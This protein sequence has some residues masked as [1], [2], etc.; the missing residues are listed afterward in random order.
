M[1]IKIDK[2]TD[3]DFLA[4]LSHIPHPPSTLYIK[5]AL[6]PLHYKIVT[7]VGS[8]SCSEYSKLVVNEICQSLKGQ[9]VSI[10]SG[11]ARGID[12]HVHKAALTH[13]IHTIA[14]VGS[15]LDDSVLYPKQNL[16]LSHMILESGGALISEHS[17]F[18]SS[19][20]WMFPA[21]NRIMVGLSQLVII[22]EA[23]QK[24]GTLITSRLATDYNRDLLVVPNS[25]Y[26]TFSK[27]SN[28][29]IK[30]GAY[31]YTKPSDIFELLKLTIPE[32]MSLFD[33]IPNEIEK[34]ILDS[35]D[36]GFNRTDTILTECSPTFTVSEIIQ[37]ILQLEIG[38]IIK[39]CDGVYIVV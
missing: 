21:R 30:Q 2:I 10:L 25:I 31:V 16:P 34:C 17:Q 39:K 15:G 26:S 24:S 32:S 36:K 29:L 3:T 13:G 4:P 28:E 11:M 9:P 27:G 6:P 33:Y 18:T 5:G 38:N 35:I 7:I 22:I 14:V 23:R 20:I 19:R 8:R 1:N 37:N 12:S